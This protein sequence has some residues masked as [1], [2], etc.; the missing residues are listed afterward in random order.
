MPGSLRIWESLGPPRRSITGSMNP[1]H[2]R[3]CHA[4]A[5]T[6]GTEPTWSAGWSNTIGSRG[7]PPRCAASGAQSSSW[8]NLQR[9]WNG[10][11]LH[12]SLPRNGRL[13]ERL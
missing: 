8:R 5:T 1:A 3:G 11:H 9:F 7:E 2:N 4:D 13:L 6:H 12:A 10:T